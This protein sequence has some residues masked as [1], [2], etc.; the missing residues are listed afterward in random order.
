M[1][2][3][4]ISQILFLRNRKMMEDKSREQTL[5]NT[6]RDIQNGIV[7]QNKEYTEGNIRILAFAFP[8]R[9]VG[10]DFYD[11]IPLNNRSIGIVMGDVSGKG[12]PA[13]LVMAV[14]KTMIRDRLTSGMSPEEVL[15]VVNNEICSENP[16]GMFATVF[17]G[18][19][20]TE[21]GSMVYA[22][23]GH[24]H[25]VKTGET[26]VYL[27][28]DNGCVIGLFEDI[29]IIKGETVI[30]PGEG[31]LLYT[32]GVTEAINDKKEQYGEKRLLKVCSGNTSMNMV[33]SVAEDVERFAKGTK[34]FDD[35]TLLSVTREAGT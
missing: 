26:A 27:E 12:I 17:L 6:A 16:L 4:C 9:S 29:G 25:P 14:I 11:I 2:M 23:A 8:A 21:N 24:T 10:G 20:D 22:N 30:N 5:L 28:P 34:Q 31:L 35:L 13:A 33:R 7:P 1:V 32:D 15:N 3:I 18:I 19:I